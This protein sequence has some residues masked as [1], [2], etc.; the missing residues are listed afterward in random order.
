MVAAME[1]SKIRY[2]IRVSITC[3]LQLTTCIM[4]FI[5][6]PLEM[7]LHYFVCW[8]YGTQYLGCYHP[9][10][11]Q[12]YLYCL[13]AFRCSLVK[14]LEFSV[15]LYW[16]RNMI[17]LK[18][19][20][21]KMSLLQLCAQTRENKVLLAKCILESKLPM[22]CIIWESPSTADCLWLFVNLLSIVT[23]DPFAAV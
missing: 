20:F 9:L 5:L 16:T 15:Y 11:A 23:V 2:P 22:K 17:H 4:Y 19:Y 18:S 7:T 3:Y 6:T 14:H 12:H 10:Q 8:R 1:G 21:S 13:L